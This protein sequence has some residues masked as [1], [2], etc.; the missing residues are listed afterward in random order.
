MGNVVVMKIPTVGGLAHVITMDAYAEALPP[1]VVNFISGAGRVTMSPIMESGVVDVFAFIGGSKA[2]DTVLKSHPNPHRLKVFLSLEGKNLGIVTPDADIDI[3]AEQCTIGS[4]TFNGQRCTAIKMIFV[5]ESVASEFISKLSERVNALKAGLP[6]EAGVSITPLPEPNKIVFL[7][8]LI[9]DAVS[10]GATVV[11]AQFGGG[12]VSGNIMQ[13]A[14]VA[15]VTESM[16]LWHKEQFGPVVPVA[17]YKSIEEVHDYIRKMPFGQQ[18]AIFTKS[19]DT[20]APLIDILSTAVGRIN[21]NTQ[22]GRSPDN[23]PFSGRRSSALGTLSVT[24]ALRTFSIETV[25][26]AKATDANIAIMRGAEGV[27]N[28]L[29]AL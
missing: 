19:V 26:A 3:A 17:V 20:A 13:P 23:F 6:W 8:G 29:A 10:K 11:N 7:Q 22:C 9:D 2:A 5:H 15:P 4:T 28:F 21:I 27:S 12:L 14:V 16:D 25:I 1:G 18:A 24:E